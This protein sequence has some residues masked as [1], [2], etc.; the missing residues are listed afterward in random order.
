[1]TSSHSLIIIIILC[2]GYQLQ[3]FYNFILQ[4]MNNIFIEILL[5]DRKSKCFFKWFFIRIL[6]CWTLE[7]V[8]FSVKVWIYTKLII[9]YYRSIIFLIEF[10]LILEKL[11]F[12]IVVFSLGEKWNKYR[13]IWFEYNIEYWIIWI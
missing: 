6:N 13:Y 11:K 1:M 4:K 10:D 3:S 9:S 5:T 7:K 8:V 2:I 12:Q